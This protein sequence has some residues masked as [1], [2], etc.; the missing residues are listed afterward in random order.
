MRT[1]YIQKQGN[2]IASEN[3][4]VAA[5][6]FAQMGYNIVEADENLAYQKISEDKTAIAVGG[7]NYIRG[8]FK[9]LGVV[10]PKIDNPHIHLPQYLGREVCEATWSEIE[11]LDSFPFF[12]KPLE[13]HKLFTGYVV[14]TPQELLHA[15]LRVTLPDTKFVLSECVEFISE[16]RCF[17]LEGKLVGCKNYA[18]DFRVMPDFDIIENAIIDYQ[19]QPAGYSIDFGVTSDGR[20][21]L[22][23]MN[24]GFGLSAYG[25]NKIIYCKILEARWDEIMKNKGL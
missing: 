5:L 25:L 16:F 20:T 11:Q 17:V 8:I 14:K 6:G 2:R 7:I 22:I 9:G 3:G 13:D 10:Q 4:F 1:V 12:I 23:E 18:G 15:K 19:A 24:D 21:L